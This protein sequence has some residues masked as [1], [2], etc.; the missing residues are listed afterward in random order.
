MPP[1]RRF[2]G[3]DLL[4]VYGENTLISHLLKAR[5]ESMQAMLLDKIRK[6]L[7]PVDAVDREV[8]DYEGQQGKDER[9]HR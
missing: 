7:R 9:D 4:Y 2:E 6:E 8:Y 1:S 5:I 3:N